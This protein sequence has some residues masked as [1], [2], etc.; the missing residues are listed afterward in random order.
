MR[1]LARLAVLIWLGGMASTGLTQGFPSNSVRV[2][3]S[4]SPGGSGDILGRIVMQKVSE[5]WGQP[6]AVVNHWGG[7]SEGYVRRSAVVAPIARDGYT[8]LINSDRPLDPP[9]YHANSPGTDKIAY[10]YDLLKDFVPVVLLGLQPNILVVSAS[11]PY[12]SVM[13]LV[14]A[15]KAKEITIGHAGI[16]S[17]SHFSTERLLAASGINVKQ[18]PFAGLGPALAGLYAGSID[19]SWVLFPVAMVNIKAG[20]LRP[21]AVS[22]P[23]RNSQLSEVPT[24]GEAGISGAD[25]PNWFGIWAPAG[26]PGDVV[27]KISEDVRRALA[28]PGVRG[29]LSIIGND[30]MDLSPAEFARF[31]RDEI[32]IYAQAVQSKMPGGPGPGRSHSIDK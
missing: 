25:S 32:E 8:L 2:I 21:L 26:T 18:V 3:I 13:D 28:D 22:T 19:S 30:T 9:I 10:A 27:Q 29:K 12:R 5:Y 1:A 6:V 14:G 15:A 7:L 31:V 4:S 24:L 11:S 20:K 17:R 16:G 23:R